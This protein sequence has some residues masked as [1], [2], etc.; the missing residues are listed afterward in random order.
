MEK[1]FF[2]FVIVTALGF[3][4]VTL[5]S[6]LTQESGFGYLP[7]SSF[8]YFKYTAN[9]ISVTQ[10]MDVQV[11]I[12][13]SRRAEYVISLLLGVL[14]FWAIVGPL[15]L[16]PTN[17]AWLQHGDPST[18]YLG[19]S[20]FRRSDWSFPIGLNPAYGLE[21]SNAIIFSDSNPLLALFFKPFSLLL[22]NPF[23]YFGIWLLACYTLQSFFSWKLVGLITNSVAI[24]VLGT[25]IFL[26]SPPMMMRL[27]EHLSL[28]GHFFVIAA[29][30]LTFHPRLKRRQLTWG[31]LLL[32][33]SLVHAYLLAMVALIWLADLA[34]KT[35]ET[36][37]SLRKAVLELVTLFLLIGIICWQAGYFSVGKGVSLRGFGYY[38]MNVLSVFNAGGWSYVLPDFQGVQ[39]KHH[40]GFNFLGLGVIFLIVY[41]VPF[42]LKNC[43][44]LAEK[45][46]KFPVLLLALVAFTVFSVSNQVS[47]GPLGFEFP[48]P[49]LVLK[50]ANIFRA[51]A[52]MFWPV[53]YSIIFLVI[54]LT[55]RGQSKR[56]AIW[57]LWVAL[58]VQIADTSAVWVNIRNKMMV[59][60]NS[61][62]TTS[63]ND[64]FWEEAANKYKKV[65]WVL[66]N[67]HPPNWS[68]LATYAQKHGLATDAVYLARV[69]TNAL[70]QA[71][72]KALDA[73]ETGNYEVDS[74]YV[75][76]DSLA[77]KALL[78]ITN[79]TDLFL[80][81]DGLNVLA[82]EWKKTENFLAV[83]NEIKITDLA[84]VIKVGERILMNKSGSGVIYLTDGWSSPEKW[85]TWL[86][87]QT[88]EILLPVSGKLRSVL[89]EV[90]S[91]V[92]P[93]YPNENVVIHVNDVL[94]FEGNLT[95]F[96]N[97][98]I[99]IDIPAAMQKTMAGTNLVRIHF[100]CTNG[101]S[102]KGAGFKDNAD[103]RK[104]SFGLKAI[105]LR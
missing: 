8:C 90:N 5:V 52:R 37:S 47:I 3:I 67:N 16:I 23:Q 79:D 94:S 18:H 32:V 105:T 99:Q 101:I 51:S 66:P 72:E 63:L 87:G 59:T 82:P 95:D 27:H 46:L 43:T 62:W 103:S 39:G 14:A 97:N 68:V 92:T 40:E 89:V 45:V 84:P 75:L 11:R 98:H 30:Y 33:V 28:V 9:N 65:R 44:S 88:A 15:A 19:W 42:V 12:L 55:I 17:I 83:A 4:I 26:F 53:F 100:Q 24:R 38:G 1:L 34:Q 86:T 60:S 25:G 81:V 6:W 61:A 21:I 57:L 20:F 29:L 13:G 36:T 54:L 76:D 56:N 35:I 80:R 58:I 31:T 96:S 49:D 64:L 2:W 77:L 104:L 48:I 71:R 74:L 102:L 22:S 85:G 73:V 69:G 78:H 7:G 70:K 93:T 41:N 50:V 10:F 91:L